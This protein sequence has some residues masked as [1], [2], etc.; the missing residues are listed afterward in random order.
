MNFDARMMLLAGLT[1]MFPVDTVFPKAA[2]PMVMVVGDGDE[3]DAG[4]GDAQPP[5]VDMSTEQRE[6][7]E[8]A[9]RAYLEA[10]EARIKA[11]REARH[12]EPE[13]E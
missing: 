10:R 5:P 7:E 12:H 3:Q 9:A 6:A 1:A 2:S 4:E 11:E 8:A 13:E